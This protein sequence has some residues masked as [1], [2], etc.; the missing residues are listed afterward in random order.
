MLMKLDEKRTPK[1]NR[2][3]HRAIDLLRAI[4][5]LQGQGSGLSR[6]AKEAQLPRSTVHRILAVLVQRGLIA[7]DP[8]S[9][10]YHIGIEL[11]TLGTTAQQFTIK[12]RFRSALERISDVSEDTVYLFVRSGN[13]GLCIDRIV[14]KFPIH[15]LTLSV[16]G[17]R[18]LGV[19]AG[20]LALLAFLPED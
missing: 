1:G 13:D 10:T 6:L 15:T 3:I 8:M 20:C 19:G 4:A 16:G 7:I 14:G 17:R 9:K 11:V 18:P 2:S 5:K 12:D